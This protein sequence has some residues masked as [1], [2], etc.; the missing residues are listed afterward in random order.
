M[1]AAGAS[2][3]D[4]PDAEWALAFAAARAG[5]S[6]GYTALFRRHAPAVLAFVRAR[7]VEDPDG[8]TNEVFLGAFAGLARFEGDEAAFR[9]WLFA[10]ARNKVVDALRRRARRPVLAATEAP[11][12]AGGD[13]EQEAMA[14]LGDEWVQRT[15][16]TLTDDQRDVLL[17]RVV[18]QL[19][20]EEIAAVLGK[21]PGAVKALQRRGM[22][23][24]QRRL[25]DEGVPL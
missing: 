24:L 25:A 11:D 5:A 6:S 8:V 2:Q 7:D 3:G 22:R 20:I 12:R 15:L 13:A 23:A 16:A 9:G 19:T 1:H 10:I 17:L 4:E 21:P 18:A 14:H